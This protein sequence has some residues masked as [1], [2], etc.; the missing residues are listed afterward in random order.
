MCIRDRKWKSPDRH[1]ITIWVADFRTTASALNIRPRS[2]LKSVR[3]P[4]NVERARS[5]SPLNLVKELGVL[6]FSFRPKLTSIQYQIGVGVVRSRFCWKTSF[7][8][9]ISQSI[10]RETGRYSST[11]S[12]GWSIDCR[13]LNFQT[14]RISRTWDTGVR[15]IFVVGYQNLFTSSE[16][17]SQS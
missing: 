4:E 12:V 11:G 5:A 3:T 8:W 16:T 2:N 14:V 7:L 10:A 6:D 9:A 13:I 15:I 1:T 17:S